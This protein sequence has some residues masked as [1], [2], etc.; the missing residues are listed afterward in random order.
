MWKYLRAFVIA[1]AAG[2]GNT[3]TSATSDAPLRDVAAD[4]AAAD[5]PGD[6]SALRCDL[7]KPFGQP[8]ALSELNTTNADA[9]VRLSPD[10]RTAYV[11]SIRPGGAGD[12]DIYVA[13]R[14]DV[15]MPFGALSP[16]GGDQYG[17]RG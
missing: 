12:Y 14:P 5:A 3:N 10:E 4:V 8:T 16:I 7:A 13:T 2:C 6:V 9:Y 11:A 1:M 17:E 15:T